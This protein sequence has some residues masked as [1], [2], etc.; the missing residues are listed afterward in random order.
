[1]PVD[2]PKVEEVIQLD[3]DS[4]AVVLDALGLKVYG[5]NDGLVETSFLPI[6]EDEPLGFDAGKIF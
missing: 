1:M 4:A 6:N 3:S 5:V 2:M